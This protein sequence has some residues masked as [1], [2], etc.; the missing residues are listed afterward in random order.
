MT[1]EETNRRILDLS[2][3]LAQFV[4]DYLPDTPEAGWAAEILEATARGGTAGGGV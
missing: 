2:R 3:R 4:A 1:D